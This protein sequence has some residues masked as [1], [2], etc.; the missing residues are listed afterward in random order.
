MNEKPLSK[1]QRNTIIKQVEQSGL[2]G[3]DALRLAHKLT[4][5]AKNKR[6]DTGNT[7]PKEA[8][9]LFF[10]AISKNQY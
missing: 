1:E 6:P 7:T 8:E 3:I 4:M 2:N 5:E 10:K 9:D